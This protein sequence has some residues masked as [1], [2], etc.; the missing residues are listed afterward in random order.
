[1]EEVECNGVI[2]EKKP[3]EPQSLKGRGHDIPSIIAEE[4]A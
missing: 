4:Q 3:K 2:K 1:V